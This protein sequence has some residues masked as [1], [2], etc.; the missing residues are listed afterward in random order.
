MNTAVKTLFA[1]AFAVAAFT[2]TPQ[3]HAAEYEIDAAHAS[4]YFKTTHLGVSEIYGRFNEFDGEVAWTGE[5]GDA[6]F[7]VEIQTASVD[8]GVKKR[9]DHLRSPDFF[10]VAQHPT[11]AFASTG[12]EAKGEDRYHVTGEFTMNGRTRQITIPMTY[13]GSTEFRGTE[14]IGFSGELTIDRR[15]WGLDAWQ[16]LVGN[17]VTLMISF[18]ADKK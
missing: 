14:K 15:E 8:T 6:A 2:A 1:A 7:G 11:I 16:G 10:N 3:T 5:A 17:D 18:E 9:D 4:I 13:H 12:V